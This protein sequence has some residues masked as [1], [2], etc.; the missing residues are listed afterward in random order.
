M[1]AGVVVVALAFMGFMLMGSGNSAQ[2]SQLGTQ[3]QQ[4]VGGVQL[5][6]NQPGTG[7]QSA[8]EVSLTATASGY[9]KTQIYVKAG[10]PV[11]FSFTAKGAGCGSQLIIDKV[12]VN[13]VSSGN[14]VDATFTPP[15]PGN[16]PYHCG[17][18]MFRGVLV[19]Q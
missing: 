15:S 3:N 1:F 5:A 12:G 13:L 19:A 11:H 7:S 18:N 6:Q 17:M 16:Y 10:V 4:A 8:Q 2:A 9:D 14:T